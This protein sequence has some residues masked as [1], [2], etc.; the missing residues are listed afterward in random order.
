V[1]G[2]VKSRRRGRVVD[3]L[4]SEIK[5]A[6]KGG[7]ALGNFWSGVTCL[8]CLVVGLGVGV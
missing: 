8:L 4:V 1:G 3:G 2:L 6:W 7:A 5:E